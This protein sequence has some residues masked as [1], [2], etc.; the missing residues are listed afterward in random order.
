MRKQV[1]NAFKGT[2]LVQDWH[3]VNEVVGFMVL[4]CIKSLMG[5]HKANDKGI[6]NNMIWSKK[7]KNE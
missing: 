5:N 3:E 2:Q 4:K 6:W 1:L 7:K